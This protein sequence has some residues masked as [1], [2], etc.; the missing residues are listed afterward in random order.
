MT[1]NLANEAFNL[2][3]NNC[4]AICLDRG[5]PKSYFSYPL[6]SNLLI[7]DEEE[8]SIDIVREW[9]ISCQQTYLGIVNYHE[10]ENPVDI[11]WLNKWHDN[12]AIWNMLPRYH[13]AK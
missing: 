3:F 11:Y 1:S 13:M 6:P 5:T 9:V 7:V 4:A 12:G 8:V 2:S 10:S